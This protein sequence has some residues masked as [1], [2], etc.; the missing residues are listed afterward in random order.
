V[1]IRRWAEQTWR[2]LAELEK[3]RGVALLPLGVAEA[4]GPHLPLGTDT[5]IAE[6]MAEEAARL[7]RSRGL[8]PLILPTVSYAPAPFAAG[9]PGT[10][11]IRPAT[12]TAVLGDLMD[13]LE[14]QGLQV[15]GIANA[16]LDPAHLDAVHAALSRRQRSAMAIAFPDLTRSALASRLTREFQSGACHAGRF[17]AS[18]VL[19]RRPELVR[20]QLR[21]TLPPVPVSLVT[22]I[23]RGQATFEEA[24]MPDAYCGDPAAAEAQEGRETLALLARILAEAVLEVRPEPA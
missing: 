7:L 17:E 13:A 9:F 2:D 23:R 4:H 19:A 20:D 3:K 10:L 11:S 22:A 18:L 24:G 14:G 21:R 8:D 15:L 6:G 16:H 1:A 12:L 5:V